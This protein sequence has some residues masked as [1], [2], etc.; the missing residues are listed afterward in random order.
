MRPSLVATTGLACLLAGSPA[1]AQ[2]QAASGPRD[3][4][5]PQLRI[6]ASSQ[7]EG[8]AVLADIPPYGFVRDTPAA[9]ASLR[10]PL[11]PPAGRNDFVE[12]CRAMVEKSA[13]AHGAVRVEAASAGPQ[14]RMRDGHAA[15]V[16]FR[17]LYPGLLSSQVR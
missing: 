6:A 8:E 4:T 11:A 9:L 13:E 3:S 15:P 2:N 7:S 1:L 10:Q 16:Q 12:A 5:A 14:R 17:I